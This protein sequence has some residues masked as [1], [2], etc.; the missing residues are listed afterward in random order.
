MHKSFLYVCAL[1]SELISQKNVRVILLLENIGAPKRN[2][3]YGSITSI[4]I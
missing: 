3:P 4:L 2:I 1:N